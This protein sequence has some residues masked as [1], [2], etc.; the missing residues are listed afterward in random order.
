M[1]YFAKPRIS[2]DGYDIKAGG[3]PDEIWRLRIPQ[4]GYRQVA[5]C[6]AKGQIIRSN[7]PN[8]VQ[9]SDISESGPKN[10]EVRMLTVFGRSPGFTIL[11]CVLPGTAAPWGSVQVEVVANMSVAEP[12]SDSLYELDEGNGVVADPRNHSKYIDKVCTAV[13]Y[14]IYNGGFYLYVPE[15]ISPYPFLLP[16][17]MLWFGVTSSEHVTN[18]ILDDQTEALKAVG[19]TGQPHRVAYFWGKLVFPTS[20]TNATTPTI[21]N[22]ASFVVDE[23]VKE[24]QI[25]LITVAIP[26]IGGMA[27]RGIAARIMKIRKGAVGAPP[28]LPQKRIKP[29]DPKLLPRLT[30]TTEEQI[31]ALANEHPGL[32]RTNAERAVRGP[33]GSIPV[34]SG[35]QRVSPT[36]DVPKA[37]DIEFRQLTPDGNV[38]LRR[39]VKVWTGTQG[40]FDA[41]LSD[42]ADQLIAGGG[43][44]E[45][46][47]QVP[48]GTNARSVVQRFKGAGGLSRDQQGVRLGRYRSMKLTMVDES[49]SVLLDEP[50]E[51]PPLRTQ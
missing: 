24:V 45:I 18:K 39:E 22:T 11:D 6:A 49:G 42:A 35:A 29:S 36:G 19:G 23:L 40:R 7:N 17:N 2:Q 30:L 3:A 41:A 8:V 4:G 25:E 34:L 37:A 10:A 50:L 51:L 15:D 21:V 46:F 13:G 5:L 47:V 1:S 43:G 9:A 48:T 12:P 31:S 32:T 26:I 27:G 33:D 38:V 16:E 14:G 44:G 20:F 28:R